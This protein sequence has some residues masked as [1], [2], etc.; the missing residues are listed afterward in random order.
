MQIT[1]DF[2]LIF[3]QAAVYFKIIYKQKK[4]T[5]FQNKNSSKQFTKFVR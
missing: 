1:N 2:E 5:Y 4:A 3:M